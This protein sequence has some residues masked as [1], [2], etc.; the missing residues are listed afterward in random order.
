MSG[1]EGK[2]PED[3]EAL[4]ERMRVGV[5]PVAILNRHANAPC[6]TL[7]RELFPPFDFAS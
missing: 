5:Y 3:T 7:P 6:A 2:P 1:L 4:V